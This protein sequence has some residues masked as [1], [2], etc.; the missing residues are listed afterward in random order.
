M[1]LHI[2]TAS[3]D[4]VVKIWDSRA[5]G[6]SSGSSGNLQQLAQVPT[7]GRIT[8]MVLSAPDRR[9]AA[10]AVAGA[11]GA[12]AAA[13]ADGKQMQVS[14]LKA[15]GIADTFIIAASDTII[16]AA[17]PSCSSNLGQPHAVCCEKVCQLA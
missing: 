12:A 2:A 17:L 14:S 3:S 9:P 10:A 15:T 13:A 1:P 4:G 6:S 8:G 16:I 11:G 5:F 7:N